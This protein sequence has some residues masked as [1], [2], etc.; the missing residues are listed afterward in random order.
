MR[1]RSEKEIRTDVCIVGSGGAGL[2]AAIEARR[3]GVDVLLLDKVVIATNN[4]TRYS[5]GGF[6]AALPGIL[7]NAYTKI[8]DS[9]R[10]HFEAAL[11]HGEYLNDQ[12]LIETLCY[13]APA[14]VLE[15]KDFGVEH[16]RDLYLKVP[17]P[18]GTG[19]VKPLLETG[20][21]L[22]VKTKP[23]LVVAELIVQKGAVKGLWGFDIFN[24]HWFTIYA[25]SVILTT[26]G[27]GEI[28]ERNDTTY[29]TTGDGYALAYRAGATLRD[30]EI[31]QF[32][33]YVQA[34]SG[35]PMMDRHECEAEFY[36]IL[37]NREGEDFLKK[38]MPPSKE[39]LDAFHKQ[40]GAHL[41][42]IR[43]RVA[44]AMAFEVH[45]GKGDQGAV[46]F[47]LR[48]VPD[49][50]WEADI[51]SQYT[52]KCL[53]RGFDVHQNPV[54]VFP[55]AICTLGGVRINSSTETDVEGLFAAG[56]VAGGVHGAARLGGDALVETIVY[57]AR[58]GK[59]AALHALAT[60]LTKSLPKGRHA[61]T[62]L[63]TILAR[64]P[65]EAGNPQ[66]IKTRIKSIMWQEVS[67][68]RQEEGLRRAL[69]EI[70]KIG[71]EAL[72]YLFAQTSRELREAVEARNMVLVAEMVTR[73]ALM[74]RESRGGHYRLDYP[75]R[76][77]RD[78]LVN[79]FIREKAGRMALKREPIHLVKMKPQKMSK[80]GLEVRG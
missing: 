56:E 63:E 38:Y 39:A 45:S 21:A 58:A 69:S 23:G 80:F 78:W 54:H 52:R 66:A 14:R 30:M 67:L 71:D 43:E 27:A 64:S 44:R 31:V 22:G 79:L 11:V 15:L 1:F 65:N 74:R 6:K 16:F 28:F 76:D 8:F 62:K 55:G 24:G 50:K 37:R 57:G 35:L 42:D 2:R 32:E 4:N 33:P 12:E 3:H 72:P 19:I 48:H 34:E 18:H 75:Y 5:G 40:F 9:P 53:L 61:R 17:Y 73:S 46:L 26:G 47:D 49:E 7:S 60:P 41:T 29:N 10:E 70:Q 13:D 25:K 36:G 68:L 77:D 51:A 59:A 20:K